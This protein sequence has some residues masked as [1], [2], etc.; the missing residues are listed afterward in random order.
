MTESRDETE[1]RTVNTTTVTNTRENRMTQQEIEDIE[2]MVAKGVR[3]Q[4]GA[5]SEQ[6]LTRLEKRLRNEK[7]RRGL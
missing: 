1:T 3:S 6:V 4:M 7:S 5:I 2:D